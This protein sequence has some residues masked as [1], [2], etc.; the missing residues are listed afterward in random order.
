MI[1]NRVTGRNKIQDA[2][3]EHDYELIRRID[4][5]RHVH[6]IRRNDNPEDVRI[7]NRVHLR[8]KNVQMRFERKRG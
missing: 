1:R 2:W 3:C 8:E 6:E 7:V 4:P 5:E